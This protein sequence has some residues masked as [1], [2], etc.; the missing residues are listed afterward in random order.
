M[1]NTSSVPL[2]DRG[3]GLLGQGPFDSVA[4]EISKFSSWDVIKNPSGLINVAESHNY[5]MEDFMEE[6]YRQIF[7]KITY[8]QC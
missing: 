6:S 7:Q 8:P 5:L 2:S 3:L 4:K 1:E